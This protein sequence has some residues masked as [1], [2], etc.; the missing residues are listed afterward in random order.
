MFAGRVADTRLHVDPLDRLRARVGITIFDI[1]AGSG[2]RCGCLCLSCTCVRL[3]CRVCRLRHVYPPSLWLEPTTSFRH[4]VRRR[5][6]TL[7]K[8]R[9]E[10]AQSTTSSSLSSSVRAIMRV[11]V[12][13]CVGFVELTLTMAERMRGFFVYSS[14][15]LL[16]PLAQLHTALT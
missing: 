10:T 5:V 9:Y 4:I 2:C 15:L 16:P 11:F 1:E 12:C 8:R 7:W 14:L 6:R 3:L 13:V